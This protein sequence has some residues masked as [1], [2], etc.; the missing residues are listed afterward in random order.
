MPL[1]VESL[2]KECS[3]ELPPTTIAAA[4][5]AVEVQGESPATWSFTAVS[6]SV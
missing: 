1:D 3:E 5:Q 6:M 4:I 2:M